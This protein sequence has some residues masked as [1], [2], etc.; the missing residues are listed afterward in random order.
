[1][2]IKNIPFW[3][4]DTTYIVDLHEETC[5]EKTLYEAKVCKVTI[6]LNGSASFTF[7]TSENREVSIG[8][9]A[10]VYHDVND[11]RGKKRNLC[12]R[13]LLTD[14]LLAILKVSGKCY[15]RTLGY[16][17]R[18]IITPKGFVIGSDLRVKPVE[19]PASWIFTRTTVDGKEVWSHNAN[20]NS[21]P[22]NQIYDSKDDAYASQV[23][24]IKKLD[25]TTQ[26]I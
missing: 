6:D 20:F 23:V 16:N 26:V 25:G 24:Q 19:F 10:D 8:A 4:L 11:Y 1:M 5:R 17:K 7:K 13:Y 12:T 3:D 15:T 22:N 9:D 2:E 14:E 18:N 21:V